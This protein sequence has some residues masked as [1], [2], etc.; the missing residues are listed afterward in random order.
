MHRHDAVTLDELRALEPDAVLVSPGPGPPRGRRRV[1]QRRDPRLRRG[2]RAR[3]RRVPRPPV[4]RP[5]LRR[6]GR[7]R[8]ARDARQDVGD[9]ATRARACSPGCP[10]PF[11]ATRYHSLVVARD[12]VPDVLEIT[13]RVRGRAGDGAAPPRAADRGRAVPPRVDPHRGRPR[14]PRA[15]SSSPSVASPS[16]GQAGARPARP[17]R[18]RRRPATRAHRRRARAAARCRRAAAPSPR[19]AAGGTIPRTAPGDGGVSSASGPRVAQRR[20]S[21]HSSH[22]GRAGGTP[23][24]RGP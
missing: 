6:R 13:R 24:R 5:A 7:A 2:R 21:G 9:H 23:S 20:R 17:R 8:P 11:T 3:A 15:T 19:R 14:A 10:T 12:S 4:H 1:L 22:A 16:L 18:G